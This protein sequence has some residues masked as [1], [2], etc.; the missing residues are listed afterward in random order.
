M[1]P[2][3]ATLAASWLERHDHVLVAAASV[4]VAIGLALLVDRAFAR[5]GRRLAVRVGGDER[6]PVADTRLRFLRRL[7]VAVILAF[8]LFLA[9]GQFAGLHRVVTSVLASGALVAAVVGFAARQTLANAVAGVMLAITQPLR[10]GDVVCVEGETGAVEDV[11]LNYSVLRTGEG[12]R[13]FI[14]NE[15]LAAGVLRNDSIVEGT[16][17]PQAEFWVP[18]ATPSEATLAALARALPDTGLAV[19]EI[20]PEGVRYIAGGPAVPAAERAAR[21]ADMRRAGL[22]ELQSAEL[23]GGQG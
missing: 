6:S 3:A 9:L 2:D 7:A 4:L 18:F 21:E 15:R 8:G 11:R 20:A 10:I 23:L 17:V 14:P 16:V 1:P 13:V 22:R 12:R 5:R 19:A